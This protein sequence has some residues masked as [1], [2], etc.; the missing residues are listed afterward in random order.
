MDSKLS[1]IVTYFLYALM[2]VS[3]ILVILFY[4]GKVVPGTEDT[5]F[6]EPVIT[7]TILLWAG[8]LI[9]LTAIL[10]LVFPIINIV[11][12]PKAA[13][14]T[15]FTVLGAALLIFIAW[16][17]ASNAVLDMPH[18]EGKDNVPST[19]KLAGTGLFTTYI[20]AG[21]AVLTILYSEISKYFK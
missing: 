10:S 21:L 11:T 17:L 4:F 1:N 2:F 13:K 8:I 12:N 20:L 3:V 7:K 16:M 6:E 15:L 18:Y 5:N 19:L 14:G 9:G